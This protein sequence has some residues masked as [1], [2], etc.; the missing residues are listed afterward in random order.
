MTLYEDY[1]NPILKVTQL[2][3]LSLNNRTELDVQEGVGL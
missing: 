1:S 2:R 3:T